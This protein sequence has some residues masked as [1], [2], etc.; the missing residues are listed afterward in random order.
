M[1]AW[2]H[3]N[4][5]SLLQSVGIGGSLLFTA[6]AL[7]K[8]LQAKRVSEYLTLAS[9]HRRLWSNLHR[10]P[11]LAQVLAPE[12]DLAT[13]PVTNEEWLFLELVFVHFHT[14]WLLAR[15]GSLTPMSVLAMDAG[16][17]FQLPAPAR[18]WEKVKTAK[19]P[20]F[21]RFIDDAVKMNVAKAELQA[22]IAQKNQTT[23]G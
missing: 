23:S 9:Q 8:D 16:E 17:F 21:V 1:T 10:R 6:F 2:L 15:E 14:G 13:Q 7:R 11:G 12:R 19:E 18:V 4:W 20:E 3:E 5:F 22:S